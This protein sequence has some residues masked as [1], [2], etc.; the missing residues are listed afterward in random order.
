MWDHLVGLVVKVS[1]SRGADLGLSCRLCQDFSRSG[2]T[3][4]LE[5]GTPV[6]SLPDVWCYD[7]SAWTGWPGISIL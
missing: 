1:A 7:V 4:D 3:S 6:A 2:H 5:I